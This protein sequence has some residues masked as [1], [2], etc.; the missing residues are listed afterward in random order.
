MCGSLQLSKTEKEIIRSG[1]IV[2]GVNAPLGA[3]IYWGNL[4]GASTCFA[5][6]EKVNKE[7]ST[8]AGLT[9]KSVTLVPVIGWE[10]RGRPFRKEGKAVFLTV[11]DSLHRR[12]SV[13][14]TREIKGRR[15]PAMA[16]EGPGTEQGRSPTT[17]LV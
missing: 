7:K 14:V 17:A 6:V 9:I 12:R 8:W 4:Q 10:E 13:L 1:N 3:F 11:E 5:R 15:A 16:T 2:K